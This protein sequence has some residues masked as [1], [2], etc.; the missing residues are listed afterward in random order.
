MK[1]HAPTIDPVMI[2]YRFTGGNFAAKTMHGS[3]KFKS[4]ML[5]E[6]EAMNL[7]HHPKL[8]R[9]VDAYDARDEMT[10]I[11]ELCTGGELLETV[12]SG[13]Y[14]TEIEV[15]RI[16]RQVLEGVEYMHSKGIG[17]LGLTPRD[18]LFVRPGGTYV[19][20]CDFSLSHRVVGNVKLDYGQPEFVAPEIVNMEGAGFGSDMWACGII[21]YLLLSGVSPFRGQ[22]GGS[23]LPLLTMPDQYWYRSLV[24][25]SKFG[26]TRLL[27]DSFFSLFL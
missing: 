27:K 21:T 10:L 12:T 5:N 15:A 6:F 3:G 25:G 9:M 2:P 16:V 17:H 20:I 7:L 14:V 22:V 26:C 13:K 4:W 23:N 18:V 24:M 19:K 8:T 11:S 1:E